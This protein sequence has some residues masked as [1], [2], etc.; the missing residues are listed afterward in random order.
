MNREKFAA[1]WLTKIAR[2]RPRRTPILMVLIA[3]IPASFSTAIGQSI[4]KVVTVDSGLQ[5]EG[6]LSGVPEII[7][8]SGV[9]QAYGTQPIVRIDDGMRQVFR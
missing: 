9:F 5:F 8:G 7:E 4:Q 1:G 6:E 3:S 2:C